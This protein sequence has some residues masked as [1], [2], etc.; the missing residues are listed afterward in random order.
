M[1]HPHRLGD[2]APPHTLKENGEENLQIDLSSH[3]DQEHKQLQFMERG[4]SSLIPKQQL[5]VSM[6]MKDKD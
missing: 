3:D 6:S 5:Q 1:T 2:L 4:N